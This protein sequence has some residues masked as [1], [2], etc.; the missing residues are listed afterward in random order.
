[1][2]SLGFRTRL[3]VSNGQ[4]FV[5]SEP[6]LHPKIRAGNSGAYVS[7]LHIQP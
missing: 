1:M 3:K 4:E 6:T 5:Q 2:V 7:A